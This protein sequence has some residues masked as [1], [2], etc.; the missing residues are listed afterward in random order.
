MTTPTFCPAFIFR[1]SGPG[2]GF[3]SHAGQPV[4]ILECLTFPGDTQPLYDIMASDLWIGTAE[5]GELEPM[6]P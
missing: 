6:Y 5:A 2:F 3:E 1:P 4:M